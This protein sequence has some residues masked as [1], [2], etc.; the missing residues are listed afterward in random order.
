MH[1]LG[2][3]EAPTY[4]ESV[5]QTRRLLVLCA[6]FFAA[7]ALASSPAKAA[8]PL[9]AFNLTPEYQ[10]LWHYW[11]YVNGQV[12]QRQPA[13]ALA[14]MRTELFN[15]AS[16]SYAMVNARD[17]KRRQY[18]SA[19]VSAQKEGQLA[20]LRSQRAAALRDLEI[21]FKF[22]KA[23]ESRPFTKRIEKL[24][25]RIKRAVAAHAGKE[26]AAARRSLAETKRKL[27]AVIGPLR[28]TFGREIKRI[29]ALVETAIGG[30]VE[31]WD[32]EADRLDTVDD[33]LFEAENDEVERVER[34]T[35]YLIDSME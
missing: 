27:R 26:A 1:K 2:A 22:A 6:L 7:S 9:P 35:E 14:A 32:E 30:V 19:Y 17:T 25:R 28:S 34:D 15:R 4:G 5:S 8:A 18:S 29:T 3:L 33:E 11:Y 10:S 16:A 12:G 21:Q 13:G 20:A 24:E 31:T 23:Q